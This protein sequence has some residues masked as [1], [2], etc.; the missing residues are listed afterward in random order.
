MSVVSTC[1]PQF[2]FTA[3]E[4]NAGSGLARASRPTFLGRRFGFGF[5]M[6]MMAHVA[7]RLAAQYLLMRVETLHHHVHLTGHA[8]RRLGVEFKAGMVSAH[9][10]A[11][12]AADAE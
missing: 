10:M 2:H 1:P 3:A 8:F 9:D 12:V 7:G 4:A 6:P 5:G 11:E